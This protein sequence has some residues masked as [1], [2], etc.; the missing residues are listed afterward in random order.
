VRK[1]DFL[2][3]IVLLLCLL[4]ACLS[5]E[6]GNASLFQTF[7]FF[8]TEEVE[9]A[10]DATLTLDPALFPFLF[11]LLLYELINLSTLFCFF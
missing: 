11:E 8:A 3:I 2:R 9:M 6:E 10:G 7:I 1:A 4:L 5:R